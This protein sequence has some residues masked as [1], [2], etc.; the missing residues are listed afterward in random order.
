MRRRKAAEF[1]KP[2]SDLTPDRI[3]SRIRLPLQSVL[4]RSVSVDVLAKGAVAL[5]GLET[6]QLDPRSQIAFLA[7]FLP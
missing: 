5:K 1:A 6:K 3:G 4:F 2:D 7:R